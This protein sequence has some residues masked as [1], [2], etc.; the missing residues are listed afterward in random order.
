VP[1]LGAARRG[2]NIS[3]RAVMQTNTIVSFRRGE[4][5]CGRACF[6]GQ[7]VRQRWF[8]RVQRNFFGRK[9]IE[10]HRPQVGG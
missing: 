2:V 5:G 3:T 1:G 9:V 4:P 10:G 8:Q 7:D 6:T